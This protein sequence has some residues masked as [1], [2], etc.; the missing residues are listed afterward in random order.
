M[1]LKI[2]LSVFLQLQGQHNKLFRIFDKNNTE[3]MMQN[4]KRC[5]PSSIYSQNKDYALRIILTEKQGAN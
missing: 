3:I 1:V 2:S 4:N 5:L